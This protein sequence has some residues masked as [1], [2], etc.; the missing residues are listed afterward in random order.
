MCLSSEVSLEITFSL[1]KKVKEDI[2]M[3]WNFRMII[4]LGGSFVQKYHYSSRY[5]YSI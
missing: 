5:I 1:I 4:I 3:Y 2:F